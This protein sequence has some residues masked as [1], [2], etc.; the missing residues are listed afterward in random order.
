MKQGSLQ[1]A[2]VCDVKFCQPKNVRD[3]VYVCMYGAVHTCVA[4]GCDLATITERGEWVCPLSGAVFGV[5]DEE[6]AMYRTEDGQLVP[7]GWKMVSTN[8]RK[9][10]NKAVAA[11]VDPIEQRAR[12]VVEALFFGRAR[13]TINRAHTT[14]QNARH[15][16]LQQRYVQEQTRERRFISVPHVYCISANTVGTPLPYVI[17]DHDDAKNKARVDRCVHTIVQVWNTLVLPVYAIE[18]HVSVPEAAGRPHMDQCIMGVLALM[19]LGHE[20]IHHVG[21][22]SKHLPHEQDMAEFGISQVR[23]KRRMGRTALAVLPF[24]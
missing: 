9:T 23:L 3:N 15:E 16:Q 12:T 10:G 13:A 1:F 24:K 7:L 2:H 8:K 6:P 4:D 11:T 19:V 14:R 5:D 20:L 18:K 21:W 22:V 17:L